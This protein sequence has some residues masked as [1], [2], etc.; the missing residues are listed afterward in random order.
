MALVPDF[1]TSQI[2]VQ[3]YVHTMLKFVYVALL[4]A[5]KVQPSTSEVLLDAWMSPQCQ[6][7]YCPAHNVEQ[8][9]AN[10]HMSMQET[11]LHTPRACTRQDQLKML[12]G[13]RTLN[14]N[15]VVV[16]HKYKF[17]YLEVRKAY[18]STIRNILSKFFRSDFFW[19]RNE[20]H[21]VNCLG[22]KGRCSSMCL[23]KGTVR[24]YLIF[25]F[26]RNPV[27]RFYSAVKQ[28]MV[29]WNKKEISYPELEKV[30]QRLN[31]HNEVWD[32]HLETQAHS[33][34]SPIGKA[35]YSI[36]LDFIGR[37]ETFQEDLQK[38]LQLIQEHSGLLVSN[39]SAIYEEASRAANPGGDRKETVLRFKSNELD[40]K[41]REA[42]AQDMLCFAY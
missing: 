28:S 14:A 34:S 3:L 23:S 33:L 10:Q 16:N 32:H 20:E 38:V 2:L 1:S 22:I 31:L 35:E 8:G 6:L 12:K 39:M 5:I 21:D 41:V 29:M 40:D 9:S 7:Y 19:C 37:V 15:E 36:P 18:S 24:D 26:V 42:Y 25:T 27:E 30:L 4:T 17:V 11:R 13:S